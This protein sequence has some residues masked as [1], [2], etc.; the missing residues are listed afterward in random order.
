MTRLSAGLLAI[1]VMALPALASPPAAQRA[2]DPPEKLGVPKSWIPETKPK[3]TIDA[4]VIIPRAPNEPGGCIT[5]DAPIGE[6][7]KLAAKETTAAITSM[8]QGESIT[9]LQRLAQVAV[10]PAEKIGVLRLRFLAAAT[11]GDRAGQ[12]Q[13]LAA[14]AT[15]GQLCR[16]ELEKVTIAIDQL[17]KPEPPAAPQSVP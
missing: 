11:S 10:T 2:A 14:L 16:D 13:A 17:R 8:N 1:A 9:R 6:A 7:F 4:E 15:S 3:E 12:L 5:V